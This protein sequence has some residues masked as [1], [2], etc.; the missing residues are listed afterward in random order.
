MSGILKGV[1]KVFKKIVTSKIFKIVAI[2]AAVYFT[3]GIAAAAMGSSFAAGL[4]MI[5]EAAGML[6]I[7]IAAGASS[8]VSGVA[9]GFGALDAS[10]A[11]GG[12]EAVA[13]PAITGSVGAA[14]AAGSAG[15]A[16]GWF[17][18]MSEGSKQVMLMSAV[19]G[20]AQAG[21]GALA[22]KN[23]ADAEQ[24]RYDQT[25]ED[26]LAGQKSVD[27]TKINWRGGGAVNA[28]VVTGAPVAAGAPVAPTV[29]GIVDRTLQT[30]GG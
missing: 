29:T 17:A 16:P 27:I 25:R 11:I 24:D 5:G 1:A 15:S 23:A 26:K 12:A 22:A 19:S 21:L 18:G 7:D 3:G 9:G 28:P 20:A 8:A 30:G 2:A 6:G 14:G 13:A 10:M 4:P